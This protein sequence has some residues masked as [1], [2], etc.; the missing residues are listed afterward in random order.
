MKQFLSNG[1]RSDV[2][3]GVTYKIKVNPSIWNALLQIDSLTNL[4]LKKYNDVNKTIDCVM[5]RKQNI[6]RP[7][8]DKF[9][10]YI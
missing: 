1:N 8:T 3:I 10:L 7:T 4:E 2:W 6:P 5:F 9:I